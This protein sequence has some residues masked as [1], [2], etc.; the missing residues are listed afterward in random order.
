MSSKQMISRTQYLYAV[1]V[2]LHFN[3]FTPATAED[4]KAALKTFDEHFHFMTLIDP[5]SIKE[6]LHTAGLLS[7]DHST[8]ATAGLVMEKLLKH[9][10]NCVELKGAEIFIS[11]IDVLH[12]D[13][14]YGILSDYL[15]SKSLCMCIETV[16]N[17]YYY[18]RLHVVW[19]S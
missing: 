4:N 2:Y 5:S 1:Q 7:T 15:F 13:G 9:I 14:R 11:F 6:Q 18:R 17:N 16:V 12:S 10:R 19:W 8:S 3:I